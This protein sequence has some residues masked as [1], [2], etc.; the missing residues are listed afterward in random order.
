MSTRATIK[1]IEGEDTVWVYHHCD[2]Y[3]D[4]IGSDMKKY[5]DTLDYWDAYD[6]ATDLIK[7]KKCGATNNIWTGKTTPG[8]DGYELTSGQHGDEN[9]GY[10][11]DCDKKT[12]TC[13]RIGWDEYDWKEDKIVEIP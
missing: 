5:L 8:D 7:G 13:Y 3:P 11:I 4:G 10:I 6:I 1:I 12:I 2:G 9:Y